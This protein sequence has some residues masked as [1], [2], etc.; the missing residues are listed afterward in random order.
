MIWTWADRQITEED[1]RK[2][3]VKMTELAAKQNRYIRK[4]VPKAEA[5]QYFPGK[6]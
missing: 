6:G 3:E 1:L 2:L 5:I 4:E